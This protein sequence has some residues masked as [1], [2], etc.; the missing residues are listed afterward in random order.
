MSKI[1]I[2]VPGIGYTTDRSLLYFAGK[3]AQNA[4]YELQK[5]Q[6]SGFEKGVKGNP[7]KMKRAFSHAYEQLMEQRPSF[8]RDD[9]VLFISKSIGTAVSLRADIENDIRARHILFTPLMETMELMQQ[10]L[11]KQGKSRRSDL[12]IF[13]GLADPWAA[14]NDSMRVI[15]EQRGVE[16][17]ELPGANHSLETGNP[18]RDLEY[19]KNIMEI[20]LSDERKV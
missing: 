18:I 14:D 15:A 2:I 11:E 12:I 10:L 6:F 19:Q 7:E 9:E 1:A 4:G 8:D 13:H 20:V 17:H 3:V 5:I 16:Y